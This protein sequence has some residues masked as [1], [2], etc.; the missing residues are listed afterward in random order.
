MTTGIDLALD[1]HETGA[2]E[3][4]VFDTLVDAFVGDQP[5]VDDIILSEEQQ[6]LYDLI[7]A[8]L[9]DPSAK[10]LRIGGFAGTGKTTVIKKVCQSLLIPYAVSAFTGKAV[11]VLRKKGVGI[12]QTLHSLLY[13]VQIEGGKLK[14]VPRPYI[15]AKLVIVDEGSMVS[16]PLYNDLCAH[17]CK[18]IFFGDPAQLEPIGE[19]PNLMRNCDFVLTQIHRQ[20]AGSPIIQ[21]AHR[22]R[23]GGSLKFGYWESEDQQSTLWVTKDADDIEHLVYDLA[24][25]AKNATRHLLNKKHRFEIGREEP[26]VVGETVICLQNKKEMGL[27]NGMILN[28]KEIVKEDRIGGLNGDDIFVCDVVDDLGQQYPNVPISK[29]WFGQNFNSGEQFGKPSI[30][31]DYAYGITCHKSQGSEADRVLVIEETLPKT[32]MNRWKY[33]AITRAAKELTYLA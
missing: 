17:D 21:L 33:T 19:N 2:I 20:A 14:M 6:Q 32:D 11:A 1:A 12:A 31:F 9:A 24:I 26:L 7:Q 16:T 10:E 18:R 15:F 27:Y 8:F 4:N 30:A 28:V 25:C 5:A 13:K 23:E 29:H 22:I 3:D